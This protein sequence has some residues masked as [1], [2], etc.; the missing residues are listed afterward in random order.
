[1]WEFSKETYTQLLGVMADEDYGDITSITDGFDITVE[2]KADSYKGK[3]VVKI[4]SIRPKPKST[5]LSADSTEVEKWLQNQVDV[6]TLHK[7]HSYDEIKQFLNDWINTPDEQSSGETAA[8]EPVNQVKDDLPFTVEEKVTPKKV[9][10]SSNDKFD[11]L[12]A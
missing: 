1:L 11:K 7:R 2:G 5:P 10:K 12:F 3:P 6:F 4:S 8:E 9:T